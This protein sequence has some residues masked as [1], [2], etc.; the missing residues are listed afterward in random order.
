MD[1]TPFDLGGKRAL[2]TGGGR[3]IGRACALAL[4]RA[5]AEVVVASRTEEQL[6][7]VVEAIAARGGKARGRRCDIG[8][9]D[10]TAGLLEDL[11]RRDEPLDI[12]VNNA[13]ISPIYKNVAA[14]EKEEWE[15]VLAV[16]LNAAVRLLRKIGGAMVQRRRGSIVNITSVGA[17]RALPRLAPYSAGKA[18]LGQL[19]RDLAVEWAPFGVRL[20]AVAPAYIET[21]MTAG[22]HGNELLRRQVIDRTPLGR[23]GQPHEVAWAVVFLASEAASYVTGSTLFVD[24]GWT[25][26]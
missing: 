21:A 3:G 15:L 4:A 9:P 19:T 22:V 7:E 20:N 5:G 12:L 17:V 11:S 18:A 6:E 14:V 24:G 16:N 26:I 23:F 13:A 1:S 25:C 2:V 8:D 10:D